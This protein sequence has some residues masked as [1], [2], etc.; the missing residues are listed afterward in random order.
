MKKEGKPLFFH[1]SALFPVY[2]SVAIR[3]RIV[4]ISLSSS[5]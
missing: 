3:S 1:C 5:F 2:W 4:L